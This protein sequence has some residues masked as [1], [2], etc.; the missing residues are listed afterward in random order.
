MKNWRES[1][2][3]SKMEFSTQWF[4]KPYASQKHI[5]TRKG[6]DGIRPNFYL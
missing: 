1:E 4:I 6:N 3:S 2:R 5:H